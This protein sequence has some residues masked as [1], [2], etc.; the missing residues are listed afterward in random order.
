M[1]LSWTLGFLLTTA[2]TLSAQDSGHFAVMPTDPAKP[3]SVWA[4]QTSGSIRVKGYEGKDV[5]VEKRGYQ[6]AATAAAPTGLHQLSLNGGGFNVTETNNR[7]TVLTTGSAQRLDLDMQVPAKTILHLKTATGH[8]IQADNVTGEVDA[9][10]QSGAILINGISGVASA[11]TITGRI[12]V[13]FTQVDPLRPMA[14]SSSRGTIDLTF[15]A[16]LKANLRIE[17]QHGRFY[18]DF[19]TEQTASTSA[20]PAA[21]DTK[22]RYEVRSGKSVIIKLNGGGPEIQV[23]NYAGAIVI[24][25]GK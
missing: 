15:P 5:I 23:S 2:I 20:A 22:N 10:S 11:N 17:N 14:F 18:T 6:A 9:S 13:V 12:Q 21:S 16:S 24:H 1:R 4:D 3:V 7:V 25:K 19:D 8:V